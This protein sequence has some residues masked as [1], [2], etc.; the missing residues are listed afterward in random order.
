M[1]TPPFN[2]DLPGEQRGERQAGL[3]N[4]LSNF[5]PI[6]TAEARGGRSQAGNLQ[7]PRADPGTIQSR[8]AEARSNIINELQ[9]N[10]GLRNTLDLIA[11]GEVGSQGKAAVLGWLETAMN[12]AAAEASQQG[13]AA[14]GRD[15]LNYLNNRSYFPDTWGKI[16]SGRIKGGALTDDLL[17]EVG[18]GSNTTKGS[19]GNST[20]KSEG[21][22]FGGNPTN[23]TIGREHY[24]VENYGHHAAWYNAMGA[25]PAGGG[26]GSDYAVGPYDPG[27]AVAAEPSQ[28]A[29]PR[30]LAKGGHV[31]EGERV[32]VGEEGP[33]YFVPDR[34]GTVWPH[35]PQ[36]RR[37]RGDID[38]WP[39]LP[40][41]DYPGRYGGVEREMLRQTR[42]AQD[43]KPS[44]MDMIDS[45]RLPLNE[46]NWRRMLNDPSLIALGRSRMDDR[47]EGIDPGA[48][49]YGAFMP[50][51]APA[52]E[53]PDPENPMAQE[54]GY[55]SIKRRPLRVGR[56]SY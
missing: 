54:L 37:P 56:Q 21:S 13:R 51:P 45:G 26:I 4:F 14:T 53:P 29:A 27:A 48:E 50:A 24:G 39:K 18:A 47:R 25:L 6:S 5:N 23:A 33:E 43:P 11:T 30:G 7:A 3:F 31:A 46:A 32:V 12:K 28:E 36:A 10:Q 15:L 16:E 40:A 38:R 1:I 55:G 49:Q 8:L 35:M 17:S 34:P 44:L 41:V 52:A 19:T 42:A 20:S 2:P 9:T 22:R